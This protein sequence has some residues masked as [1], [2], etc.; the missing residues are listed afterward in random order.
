MT[1]APEL[2]I[3]F[4]SVV[5]AAKFLKVKESTIYQWV[6]ER[7]IPFRKHGARVVLVRDE[8]LSWSESQAVRMRQP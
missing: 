1:R 7:K 4:L 5:E 3:V 8:L 6:H 2:S